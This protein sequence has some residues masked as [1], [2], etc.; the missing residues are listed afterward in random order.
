[1]GG[2]AAICV[3]HIRLAGKLSTPPPIPRARQ[4]TSRMLMGEVRMGKRGWSPGSPQKRGSFPL[5]FGRVLAATA[6]NSAATAVRRDAFSPRTPRTK[7][8][9][10][11][12]R[13]F[14]LSK[15]GGKH[16]STQTTGG[17]QYKSGCLRNGIR[18]RRGSRNWVK[19]CDTAGEG[20]RGS[21]LFLSPGMGGSDRPHPTQP[22]PRRG[23]R[24]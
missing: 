24:P 4:T 16:N 18:V 2:G 11:D 9:G 23:H 5:D 8:R 3:G 1:L 6:C 22:P 15:R 14:P 17:R 19:P 20:G 13:T 12:R 21:G 10:T 7:T